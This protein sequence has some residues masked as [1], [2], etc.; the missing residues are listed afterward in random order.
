MCLLQ[1]VEV[2]T[3]VL[4]VVMHC[5]GCASSVKRAVARI[6]GTFLNLVFSA[7][8]DICISCC[9]FSPSSVVGMQAARPSAATRK[10]A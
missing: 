10:N 1:T 8:I 3:V 6:P 4:K 9:L 5:E 7:H 2:K